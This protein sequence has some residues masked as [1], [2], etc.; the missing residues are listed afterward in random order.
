MSKRQEIRQRRRREQVR[1]R[2]L[3][4]GGMVLVALV[5]TFALVV[6]TVNQ[7]RTAA[8]ATRAALS[9]TPVPVIQ[10]TPRPITAKVV[11]R[12]MGDPNAPVKV[13]IY[14]DFR[15]VACKAYSENIEP[16]IIR[17]YVETGKVYYSYA[18]FLVIDGN[19]GTDASRRAANAA[20]CASDQ[21]KFWPYHD[22]L[23]ANQLTES[24]SLY[25]DDRLV[26]MAENVGLDMT[27]FNQC[28]S[29]KKFKADIETDINN[30]LAVNVRGTPS[31]F[32][33]DVY[34]DNFNNV[35]QAINDAL[36]AAGQ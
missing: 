26:K 32:V 13:V 10:I 16:A 14:E 27:A 25:T 24:A 3:L 6:P 7:A 19:D 1:N 17:D 4:I 30:G 28:Y 29:A 11:G 20:L 15:C 8:S 22:T 21:D 18:V 35:A 31:V 9:A 2:I 36:T 5:I 12:N 23:Y 33:N 34:V